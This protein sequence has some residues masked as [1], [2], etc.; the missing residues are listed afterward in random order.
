MKRRA[1]R[2]LTSASRCCLCAASSSLV[3]NRSRPRRGAAKPPARSALDASADAPGALA[4]INATRASARTRMLRAMPPARARGAVSAAPQG[5]VPGRGA[6]ARG[7]AGTRHACGA[8]AKPRT[9]SGIR[10]PE[11][12]APSCGCAPPAVRRAAEPLARG[13]GRDAPGCRV[14]R[15]LAP[16]D[17]AAPRCAARSTR[18][19]ALAGRPARRRPVGQTQAVHRAAGCV[20]C[21]VVE[22]HGRA[23]SHRACG[24]PGR[25]SAGVA[26]A[27]QL[28]LAGCSPV[29]GRSAT[30]RPLPV[31]RAAERARRRLARRRAR[32]RAGRA[33]PTRRP[34][35]GGYKPGLGDSTGFACAA[36]VA[37]RRR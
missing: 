26:R 16:S 13:R 9:R 32:P 18:A 37:R 4:A 34:A 25:G 28:C 30:R 2:T 22:R 5:E 19:A 36:G 3:R 10:R 11:G 8:R 7:A 27:R 20:G 14:S 17:R 24:P 21:A 33:R 23:P 29:T 31:S 12:R 35:G 15:A 1:G 6:R